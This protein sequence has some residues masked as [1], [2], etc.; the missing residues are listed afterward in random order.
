[1]VSMDDARTDRRAQ[2][3]IIP[4][5]KNLFCFY[6]LLTCVINRLSI[7]GWVLDIGCVVQNIQ[8]IREDFWGLGICPAN[9]EC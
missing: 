1:M 5:Y 7:E 8:T 2:T 6:F 9:S 4:A 3:S